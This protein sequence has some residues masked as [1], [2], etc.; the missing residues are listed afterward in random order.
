MPE[1]NCCLSYNFRL[2]SRCKKSTWIDESWCFVHDRHNVALPLSVNTSTVII[3]LLQT[4]GVWC[5]ADLTI[6]L[7]IVQQLV[8]SLSVLRLALLDRETVMRMGG[9]HDVECPHSFFSCRLRHLNRTV[10]VDYMSTYSGMPCCNYPV[11][12]ANSQRDWSHCR[13]TWIVII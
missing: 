8:F 6:L 9:P 7:M 3:H 2:V 1:R 4:C 10:C 5:V 13:S 11:D 12:L